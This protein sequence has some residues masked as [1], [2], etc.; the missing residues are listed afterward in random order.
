M[1]ESNR[2]ADSDRLYIDAEIRLTPDEVREA[3]AEW[4]NRKYLT[5]LDQYA[6]SLNYD[7]MTSS[8]ESAAV[9]LRRDD[10]RGILVRESGNQANGD[11]Q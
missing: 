3:V 4:A 11:Q 6:V 5:E 9:V 1:S 8:L 2:K 10:L 7:H